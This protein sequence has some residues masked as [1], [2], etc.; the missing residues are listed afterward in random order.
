[1]LQRFK[2]R[3]CI[4]RGH[5]LIT[6]KIVVHFLYALG[7]HTG[8]AQ[9]TTGFG[10]VVG[11]CRQQVLGGDIGIPQFSSKFFRLI[12]YLDQVIPKADLSAS[13][14]V[15]RTTDS[16]IYLSFNGLDIG[17]DLLQNRAQITFIAVKQR[18]KQMKRSDLCGLRVSGNTECSL[19]SF[20]G[21]HR[22]FINSHSIIPSSPGTPGHDD[23]KNLA[24]P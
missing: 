9:D 19:Q 3:L 24:F 7:G 4:L 22:P 2:L 15:R 1:M 13:A 10:L 6:T 21:S 5:A 17:T 16:I 14:Y 8:I 11:K 20:L 23:W 18:L 12:G